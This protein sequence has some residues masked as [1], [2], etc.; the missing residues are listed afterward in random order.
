MIYCEEPVLEKNYTVRIGEKYGKLTVDSNPFYVKYG[1]GKK[2]QRAFF[3]CECET[4]KEMNCQ[5][6]KSGDTT[7]CSVHCGSKGTQLKNGKKVC[8]K[9]GQKKTENDFYKTPR[10]K[11]GLENHCI[12]CDRNKDLERRYGI[13]TQHYQIMLTKQNHVCALC[14]K[15]GKKRLAVDHCHATGKVRGLLCHKCNT[16]IGILNEDVSLLRRA[17]DYLSAT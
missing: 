10:Y 9:C 6:V 4:R 2:K 14:G 1:N 16:A 8:G 15:K 5:R 17:I 13:T 3:V 7:T 11:D 12:E